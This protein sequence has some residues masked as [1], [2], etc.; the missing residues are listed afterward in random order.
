[1]VQKVSVPSRGEWGILHKMA[2]G[3][4]KPKAL[5]PSPLEVN[6]GS[7]SQWHTLGMEIFMFPPPLEMTGVSNSEY[8]DNISVLTRF[9]YPLEENGVSNTKDLPTLLTSIEEFPYPPELNGVS[10]AF[11]KIKPKTARFPYPFEETGGSN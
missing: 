10:K 2:F 4:I 11:G 5:F 8:E 3:K 9:P 6:G 7:Y 1:M